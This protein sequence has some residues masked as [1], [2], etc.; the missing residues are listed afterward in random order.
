MKSCSRCKKEFKEEEFR[1]M[2]ARLNKRQPMCDPCLS[3]YNKEYWVKVKDR[4]NPIKNSNTKKRRLVVIDFIVSYLKNH[5]CVDCGEKDIVVLEFDHLKD[6]KNNVSSMIQGG[7]SIETIQKEINKCEVVCAN[8]HKRR[9]AKTF[10]WY[11]N[12]GVL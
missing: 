6:K 8:C 9:T 5:P 3:E 10:N 12:E 7:N 1:I 11:K 2:N 4:R